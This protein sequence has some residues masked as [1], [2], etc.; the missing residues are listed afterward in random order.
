MTT[1]SERD[2]DRA[3]EH[4]WTPSS[5]RT[6]PD[7][8]QPDWPEPALHAVLEA[9]AAKQLRTQIDGRIADMR[10]RERIFSVLKDFKP[11]EFAASMF[12]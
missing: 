9:L 7:A 4:P 3:A 5:G 2:G 11:D 6:R 1:S 10:D 12:D 8:Q